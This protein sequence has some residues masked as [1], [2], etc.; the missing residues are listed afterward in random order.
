MPD[1]P[2]P[3][4]ELSDEGLRSSL[5]PEDYTVRRTWDLHGVDELS[6]LRGELLEEL[7][8]DVGVDGVEL[9]SV[10]EH[11]VLVASELATNALE[12]GLPPTTVTLMDRDDPR[13]Y[14]LDVADHDLSTV[15]LIPGGRAPGAGGYGLQ[16][17][18]RLSVD[19]GW[20]ATSESKHVWAEF[21]A[22]GAAAD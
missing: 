22:G 12:H 11:L 17:A 14:L 7:S 15:P 6:R 5:P 13:S 18:R 8:R 4:G 2:R 19:V 20:Y 9:G 1:L 16:I 3:V 21:S 10:P